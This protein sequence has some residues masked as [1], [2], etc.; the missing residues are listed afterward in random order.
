VLT[1]AIAI[2]CWPG[3]AA[4]A[5]WAAPPSRARTSAPT[6]HGRL[7]RPALTGSVL[8][9]LTG[10]AST[11]F[12]GLYWLRALGTAVALWMTRGAFAGAAGRP[13][14]SPL[15]VATG[16]AVFGIWLLIARH[17]EPHAVATV[18]RAS[19]RCPPPSG[20]AGWPRALWRGGD[21]A[22]RR[23]AGLPRFPPAPDRPRRLLGGRPRRRRPPPDRRA[24]SALVFGL[25]HG[26]FIAGTLAG[27]AYALD[28]AAPGK[29]GDA[30][31]SHAVTNAL[32]VVYTL[33]TATGRS[34][35]DIPLPRAKRGGGPGRGCP[36]PEDCA[37]RESRKSSSFVRCRT[38]DA[39]SAC[40][41]HE[42]SAGLASPHPASPAQTRGGVHLVPPRGHLLGRRR[43]KNPR[44]GTASARTPEALH[45]LDDHGPTA[46]T[47]TRARPR[48]RDSSASR[49]RPPGRCVRPARRW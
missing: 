31:V 14:V 11:G 10:L 2:G 7:P 33:W 17:A 36:S 49:R 9:L 22:A 15:A 8:A 25:L 40:A 28:P 37:C 19:L 6:T 41:R 45:G 42:Q 3:C 30:I 24:L 34:W 18:R 46:A 1:C 16:A 12:D 21:R 26:A 29:L 44:A 38:R 4:R 13:R 43:M 27:I 39:R 5:G 20:S 23:G 48:R 35:R 47:W 32:L